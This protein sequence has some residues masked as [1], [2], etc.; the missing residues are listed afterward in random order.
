MVGKWIIT[1]WFVEVRSFSRCCASFWELLA[2]INRKIQILPVKR[3]TLKKRPKST[4]PAFIYQPSFFLSSNL[5][6]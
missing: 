2:L 6:Q 1:F 3:Q 5:G 4:Q